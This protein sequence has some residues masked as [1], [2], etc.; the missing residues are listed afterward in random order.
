MLLVVSNGALPSPYPPRGY[1]A[2]FG[3]HITIETGGPATAIADD[4]GGRLTLGGTIG[5]YNRA[6]GTKS[7]LG[8]APTEKPRFTATGASMA[9]RG[10]DVTVSENAISGKVS[11]LRGQADRAVSDGLFYRA[12]RDLRTADPGFE[13][14]E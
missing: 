7:V 5:G 6:V 10:H 9:C 2:C 3:V 12:T 1:A 4:A 8:P 14:K 11:R 13:R